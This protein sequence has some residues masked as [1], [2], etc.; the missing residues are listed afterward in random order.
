MASE[1][2]QFFD[3]ARQ[4]F[5]LLLNSLAPSNTG[6][7]P[8]VIPVESHTA[9]LSWRE[10]VGWVRMTRDQ[11]A[12]YER[13][14][15]D[16]MKRL[17]RTVQSEFKGE[18]S[19]LEQSRDDIVSIIM[20]ADMTKNRKSLKKLIARLMVEAGLA[21][22]SYKLRQSKWYGPKQHTTN[23]RAALRTTENRLRQ[24]LDRYREP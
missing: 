1:L 2:T 5:D 9:V 16:R 13:P 23:Y 15:I 17:A 21:G 7:R 18:A 20:R 22:E 24:I 12:K 10:F 14:Q 4:D 3:H 6:R 11:L 8:H 19:F